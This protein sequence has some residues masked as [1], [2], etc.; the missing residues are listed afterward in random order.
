V[1]SGATPLALEQDR[2]VTFRATP[3]L[4]VVALLVAMTGCALPPLESGTREC[5]GMAPAV[6]QRLLADEQNDNQGLAPVAFRIRCT[7]A[8]CT[9]QEGTA[10]IVIVWSDRSVLTA[11]TSWANP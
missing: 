9:A 7:V 6:C 11:S 3:A 2:P 8:V 1:P 4:L 5:V 10:E